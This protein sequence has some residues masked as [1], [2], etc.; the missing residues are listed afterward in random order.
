MAHGRHY[1][2]LLHFIST[3]SYG[4][5]EAVAQS[6]VEQIDEQIVRVENLTICMMNQSE[7]FYE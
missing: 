3:L 6:K 7:T 1:W 5:A 4:I 2:W